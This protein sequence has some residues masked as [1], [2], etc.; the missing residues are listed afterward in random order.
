MGDGDGWT[1]CDQGHKHWGR[2]GASGLLAYHRSLDDAVRVLLQKRA[3]WGLGG[4][5]WGMFGGAN[6]SHEDPIAGA[7]RE[8]G[9]ECTLDTSVVRLVG[10][11][12]EDH[13]SWAFTSVVGWV[14]EMDHVRPASF[15][16]RRAAW[17]PVE[18]VEELKLF[19][20]FAA[21]WPMLRDALVRVV[22]IV[23]AA[24]VVGARAE[25]GWW[26]DRAG[27]NTR[28]RDD[29]AVLAGGVSD[30][31]GDLVPYD[32]VYPD[33]VQVVE[34]AARNVT[35]SESVQVS[36]APGSGDDHI[37]ELVA[38]AESGTRTLVITADRELKSRVAAAGG[39]VAGPRWLLNHL[40]K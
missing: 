16:T 23:D 2:F 32:T 7:I 10:S 15:E 27:A 39:A 6:H 19:A 29:L 1:R 8:T 40:A 17:V 35:S 9:E 37:V 31:P 36:A 5:T 26:R 11:R 3:S 22:L 4:G 33:V 21:T 13:G 30:L 38:H 12:K 18:E 20:P 28:L 14:P 24:N 34:G 25:H